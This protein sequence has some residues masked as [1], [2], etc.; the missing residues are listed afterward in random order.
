MGC[1]VSI[2]EIRRCVFGDKPY[3]V[4]ESYSREGV[5]M[6]VNSP[7]SPEIRLWDSRSNRIDCIV[8]FLFWVILLC[9]W[10]AYWRPSFLKNWAS[11]LVQASYFSVATCLLEIQALRGD[12][13]FFFADVSEGN[14]DFSLAF[15]GGTTFLF[16]PSS[17][18]AFSL[19]AF[20]CESFFRTSAFL[21][22]QGFPRLAVILR[23]GEKEILS[24][25]RVPRVLSVVERG[26]Y[27]WVD[28]EIFTQPSVIEADALPELRREMKLTAD[29]AAEGDYVLEAAGP[30]DRLPFRAQEDRV[31]FLWVYCELFTRLGVRLPC[32]DFQREVLSRCRVAAS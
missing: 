5:H 25:V 26:L 31:H 19:S 9:L 15:R 16:L 23:N 1:Q 7:R 8:S 28:E 21:H 13:S 18:F 12:V 4:S 20:S 24:K 30:S 29:R 10:A 11:R 17:H 22:P 32:T 27:G 6:E 3:D 2:F 14:D